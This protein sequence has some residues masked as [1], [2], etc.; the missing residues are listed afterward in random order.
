MTKVPCKPILL[1]D[2]DQHHTELIVEALRS[3]GLGNP[4]VSLDCGRAA[5][6]YFFDGV[7]HERAR[8]NS[9]ADC[10][11]L[12]VLDLRLP[13]MEGLEVLRRLKHDRTYELIPV[14]IL[15][16]SAVERDIRRGFDLQANAYV[17]KPVDFHEFFEKVRQAGIYWVMVNEPVPV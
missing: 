15:T 11:C 4:I 9:L 8:Y 3:G 17:T 12:V 6:E 1:V 2:D 7:N 16:T 10:P 14:M 5:L 13:D